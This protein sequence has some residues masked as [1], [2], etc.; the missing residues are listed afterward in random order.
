MPRSVTLFTG[1]WAD[2]PI[3]TMCQKAAEFGY[4]GLELACWGDHFEVDRALKDRKYCRDHWEILQDYGLTCHAISNHL[5]G[6]AVCDPIDERHREI[7]PPQ[8]WGNGEPEAV[9]KRA[10]RHMIDSAKACR[11]FFDARPGLVSRSKKRFSSVVCV[12][13][14]STR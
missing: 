9:R 13:Y 2:W 11:K 12:P 5:V 10:A 14:A 4:D 8:I 1:Q 3:D 7:L 6:Q